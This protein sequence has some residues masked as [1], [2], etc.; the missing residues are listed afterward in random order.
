MLGSTNPVRPPVR[1]LSCPPQKSRGKAALV[2][3]ALNGYKKQVAISALKSPFGPLE[4]FKAL[5]AKGAL[6]A[7]KFVVSKIEKG[8]PM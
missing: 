4:N 2:E 3:F 6:R 5:V 1:P 8:T 7:K